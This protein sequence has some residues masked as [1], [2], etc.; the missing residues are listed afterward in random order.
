MPGPAA[1]VVRVRTTGP[2]LFDP[3]KAD[4]S[5]VGGTTGSH[6]TRVAPHPEIV[7]GNM[8]ENRDWPKNLAGQQMP[9]LVHSARQ[10]PPRTSRRPLPLWASGS[11]IGH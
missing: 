8:W 7:G 3:S 10:R 5:K 9:G 2:Y 6:V 4:G 11:Q 1:D